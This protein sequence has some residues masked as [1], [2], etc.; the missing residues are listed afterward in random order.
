MPSVKVGLNHHRWDLEL[1]ITV[2]TALDLRALQFEFH[3]NLTKIVVEEFTTAFGTILTDDATKFIIP[4][5]ARA[6]HETFD[7]TSTMDARE[8]MQKVA[9]SSTIPLLDFFTGPSFTEPS[10][11]GTSL[12]SIPE[13]RT[14]VAER[15]YALLDD[16]RREF[17][18][19]VRGPAPAS[20]YLNKT[21][22]VY[23]FVRL[24]LGIRMHGSENYHRFENGVGVEDQTVGQNVSL[25]HEVR[26]ILFYR[27]V[28]VGYLF[29]TILTGY[30]R[31]KVARGYR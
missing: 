15:L 20:A 19:G 31:W 8:R 16:L 28:H 7:K 26:S 3:A 24:T 6:M 25:I 14:R 29:D 27:I 30:S 4:S 13:F 11:V 5:V 1:I 22:P 18:S 23:E 21:R 12:T 9:A 17:L 10:L 2:T